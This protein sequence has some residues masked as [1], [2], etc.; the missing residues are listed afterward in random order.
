LLKDFAS[1]TKWNFYSFAG[2]I[3]KKKK[4]CGFEGTIGSGILSTSR[5]LGNSGK[6]VL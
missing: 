4:I 2:R 6:T 1:N 5:G 3:G